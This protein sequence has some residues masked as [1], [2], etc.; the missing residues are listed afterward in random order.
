MKMDLKNV[1]LYCVFAVMVDVL[2][3]SKI[4]IWPSDM[5][6][7]SRI[8][9]LCKLGEMLNAN[10]HQ[11]TLLYVDKFIPRQPYKVYKT[12][13][14][15][16]PEHMNFDLNNNRL[17]SVSGAG[18][19]FNALKVFQFH[20]P[21]QVNQCNN[22]LADKNLMH[23]LKKENFDILVMDMYNYMCGSLII[24]FFDV[25]T[26]LYSNHGFGVE[27]WLFFPA[28]IAYVP[29]VFSKSGRASMLG[30]FLDAVDYIYTFHV[31]LPLVWQPTMHKLRTEFGYNMSIPL[32]K[33][34]HSRISI[35]LLNTDFSLEYPRPV[36]PHL[37]FIGGVFNQNPKPLQPKL[38][39]FV[40]GSGEYGF[41]VISF[42]TLM[43]NYGMEKAAMF[44]R[45]F[46]RL[47]Q[48][49]VWRYDAERPPLASNTLI[50]TW[51]PQNDLL[52]HPKARLFITHCGHSSTLEAIYHGIPVVG[53]PFL[54]DQY[55]N[56]EKLSQRNGMGITLDFD[57]L[58]ERDL[59]AAI[60]SILSEPKFARNAKLASKLFRDP[61]TSPLD[62][63]LYWFDYVIRYQGAKHLTQQ[64]Q[65]IDTMPLYQYFFLDV[66]VIAVAIIFVTLF[67]VYIIFS[68]TV[69]IIKFIT[70]T[71]SKKKQE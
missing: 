41:I 35:F 50:S 59:Q 27:P 11:V 53:M 44:A 64:Y 24:D 55:H 46:G 15:R 54:F 25:P 30:R 36:L 37:V 21:Y 5:F 38:D 57:S 19:T 34:Y 17:T 2:C 6:S 29:N 56:A 31:Y 4:L 62:T 1:L 3:A 10:G 40:S 60:L 71:H 7:N 67:A 26:V 12:V 9:K 51:I 68:Y 39:E 66:I 42:G 61:R 43:N 69:Q 13:T 14:Y 28:N 16:Q 65:P 23:G 52:G 8:D 47:P 58:T 49:V 22:L 48:R 32:F 45:V 20:Y 18:M 33:A 63:M 70:K